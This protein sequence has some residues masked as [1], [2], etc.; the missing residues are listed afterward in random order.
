MEIAIPEIYALEAIGDRVALNIVDALLAQ[1][2]GGQRTLLHYS[3][4]LSQLR[5]SR[6]PVALDLLSAHELSALRKVPLP[7]NVRT[8]FTLFNNA[9]L[10]QLGLNDTNRIDV[11]R[12]RAPASTP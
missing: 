12:V 4:P 9:A 6:D 7:D 1:Y 10:V 3:A 5:F 11:E 8:N 2:E